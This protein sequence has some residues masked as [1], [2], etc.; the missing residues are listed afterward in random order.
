[1]GNVTQLWN[2]R[3]RQGLRRYWVS[4]EDQI[5]IGGEKREQAGVLRVLPAR[6]G[7]L[8]ARLRVSDH[9]YEQPVSAGNDIAVWI[10]GLRLHIKVQ[11]VD[12]HRMLLAFGVPPGAKV[13]VT[14]E[15]QAADALSATRVS[16]GA[17]SEKPSTLDGLVG[18][19][20]TRH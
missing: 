8:C 12:E 3:S 9:E 13:C 16:E 4:F 7:E 10:N 11:A 5:V 6:E 2:P 1:M 18:I 14:L 17:V 19:C 20:Q 15:E